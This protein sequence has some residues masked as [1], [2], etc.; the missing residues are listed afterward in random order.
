MKKKIAIIG[1]FPPPI[2]GLSK[3]LD[4]LCN[5]KIKDEFDLNKIDI[6]NNKKFLSNVIRIIFSKDD[7]Y[8]LTISQSKFGNIRDLIIM[9]VIQIKKRKLIIHLHG[10]G[11]RELLDN[12]WGNFQKRI[13]IKILS[14]VDG[15]IVLGESLKKI[16]YGIVP[17]EKIFV[18]KNCVDNEFVISDKNFEDKINELDNKKFFKI[19]YLSNFI[20]E[21][22]YFKL[23]E[24]AKYCREN[25]FTNFK[26]IFAGKFFSEVDKNEFDKFI[27]DNNL[28]EI[29]E[30]RGVID[31]K[32][33]IEIFIE[34]DIFA[35]IT[36]YK[37]EG[38]PISIIESAI[39]GLLVL[40]TDHAG[41]KDIL[42][43]NNMIL[44][45]KNEFDKRKIFNILQDNLKKKEA[46][47]KILIKNREDIKKD[48]SENIYINNIEDIF[49]NI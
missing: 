7:L 20:K 15:A 44:L 14:K 22:G 5:S 18:V 33:K 23:L 39:N 24:L 40:T 17:K 19:L 30:Y 41:I 3:A 11:F 1:Q 35:L 34:C 47:R 46:L 13:N 31:G 42:D 43:N 45:K 27:L 6:K 36:K 26:F 49:K 4:T 12:E 2:H 9:K 16:F 10:G 48:F 32:S 8:Y 37:N 38:Q 21:K 25:N 28:N 29:I